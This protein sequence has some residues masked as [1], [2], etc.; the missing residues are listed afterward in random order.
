MLLLAAAVGIVLVLTVFRKPQTHG[1]RVL[2]FTIDSA[3]VRQKLTETVVVPPGSDGAGR[4]LLIF[5]HGK[6][7]DDPSPSSAI[8]TALAKLGAR[9]PD[10]V[11]P[12][13]GEGSYWHDRSTGAWADYVYDEVLPKALALLHA[14]RRRVAIGGISMGGF[15]AF[16]IAREHPHRF[17]AVGGHSAALWL[18]PGQ[19]AAGA[20]DG[21]AD[22]RRNDV[23]GA[24]VKS[25]N[26]YAGAKLWLDV[27]SEDPFR[28]ADTTFA[29]VLRAKGRKVDFHVW[30]GGH[31]DAYWES[32]WGSYLSFYAGA[33]ADCGRGG[34]G[35]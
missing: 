2:H 20:F 35:T 31:E 32:H 13:G 12:G 6:G 22:F 34:R 28:S 33:L 23:I 1:A 4:P 11:F 19:A 14:D 27:G 16:D 30:A 17:C 3:A 8:F 24:A 26:P 25:A 7:V 9:A 29:E 21:E 15:G 18:E 5:L 10:I